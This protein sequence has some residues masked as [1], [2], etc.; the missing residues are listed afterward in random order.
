[1]YLFTLQKKS[2]GHEN[3]K[4][5]EKKYERAIAQLLGGARVAFYGAIFYFCVLA[6]YG[7]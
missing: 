3:N 6:D 2:C 4:H 1:M 7:I 5:T